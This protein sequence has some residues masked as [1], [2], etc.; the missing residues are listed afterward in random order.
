MEENLVYVVAGEGI[1]CGIISKGEL[2]RGE[3][4][5]A[6]EIGHCS[7][8]FEGPVCECG[9]RGC[10]EMYCSMEV[11]KKNIRKRI[12][13]G[14]LTTLNSDFSYEELR[15]AIAKNDMLDVYKRQDEYSESSYGFRSDCI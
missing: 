8:N 1:G 9:N 3:S 11:L 7:I 14:E 6:G 13:E 2:L 10:L 4:N 5:T 12:Q 15:M